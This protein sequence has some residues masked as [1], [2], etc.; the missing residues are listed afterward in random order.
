[1]DGDNVVA[2]DAV[3][4]MG[5]MDRCRVGEVE[6]DLLLVEGDGVGETFDRGDRARKSAS[7]WEGPS[8]SATCAD[9]LMKRLYSYL[10]V[11]V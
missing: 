7:D 3:R 10:A 4:G 1:M 9:R 2:G 5:G 6:R 11:K 8:F